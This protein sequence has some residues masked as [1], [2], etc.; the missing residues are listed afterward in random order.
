[1]AEQVCVC[2]CLSYNRLNVLNFSGKRIHGC[3]AA[4]AAPASIKHKNLVFVCKQIR[5]IQPVIGHGKRA[6]DKNNGWTISCSKK[7]KAC[8]VG[9]VCAAFRE[10]PHVF[11]PLSGTN[12]ATSVS[13]RPLFFSYYAACSLRAPAR[14]GATSA[15]KR[16]IS[17]LT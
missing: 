11:P 13:V 3:V 16:A 10:V 12:P 17:S 4:A 8:P 6:V 5:D 9:R 15:M 2:T 1:M 14:A 7:P